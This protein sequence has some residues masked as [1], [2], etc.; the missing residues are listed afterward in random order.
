L[1]KRSVNVALLEN[2]MNRGFAR[3]YLILA[4]LLLP[5]PLVADVPDQDPALPCTVEIVEVEHDCGGSEPYT[6]SCVDVAYELASD[7]FVFMCLFTLAADGYACQAIPEFDSGRHRFELGYLLDEEREGGFEA[8]CLDH[9]TT[10]A[11]D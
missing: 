9:D 4:A 7:D 8:R 6:F 10:M 11:L 1:P 3:P 2:S 5:A